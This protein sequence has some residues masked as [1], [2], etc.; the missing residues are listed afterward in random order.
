[1][2]ETILSLEN[3]VQSLTDER[4]ILKRRSILLQEVVSKLKANPNL[5]LNTTDEKEGI[6]KEG[7]VRSQSSLLMYWKILVSRRT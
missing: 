7:L 2:D 5:T 3:A 4:N 6:D 1:M